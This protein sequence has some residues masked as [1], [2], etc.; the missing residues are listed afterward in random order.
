MPRTKDLAQYPD[1]FLEFTERAGLGEEVKVV[2]P[3]VK[4]ALSLRSQYYAFIGALKRK[5]YALEAPG[6]GLSPD[7][8]RL[9]D[10]AQLSYKVICQVEPTGDGTATLRWINREA[11]WQAKV[12]ATATIGGGVQIPVVLEMPASLAALATPEEGKTK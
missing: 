4:K 11:S 9:I 3:E 5:K 2:V 6:I 1:Q 7:D 12:L 8:Q 10:I